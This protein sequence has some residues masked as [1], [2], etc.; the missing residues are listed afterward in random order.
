M[1]SDLSQEE[2]MKIEELM[3]NQEKRQQFSANVS[4]RFITNFPIYCYCVFDFRV[5][6]GRRKLFGRMKIFYH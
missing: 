3:V 4:L 1:A 2:H 5:W 6:S